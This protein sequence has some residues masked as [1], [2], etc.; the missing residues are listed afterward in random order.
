VKRI[1]VKWFLKKALALA[2]SDPDHRLRHLERC[3]MSH[4]FRISACLALAS[5][6]TPR[7]DIVYRLRWN[8]D[9]VEF[10]IHESQQSVTTLSAAVVQGTYT[11]G[12]NPA[13]R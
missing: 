8:S 3:F 2:Y 10:H 7:D 6:G 5:S 9:A 13:C 4:C 1:T 12:S 11:R